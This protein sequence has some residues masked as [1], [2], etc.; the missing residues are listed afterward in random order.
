LLRACSI[1]S[2]SVGRSAWETWQRPGLR[3]GSESNIRGWDTS[4]GSPPRGVNPSLRAL[5]LPVCSRI[6][7]FGRHAWRGQLRA[8]DRVY[9]PASPLVKVCAIRAYARRYGLRLFVET[10]T[11]YGTTTAAVAGLFEKC[12]TVELSE[13]L[14]AQAARKF[15]G[16]NIECLQ[17][18]SGTV[19]PKIIAGLSA[20][21]LF[22]LDAH[23]TGGSLTADAGYDPILLEVEA[24][25]RS[26]FRH[27]A[28][29][30]DARGHNFEEIG[31]LAG[32]TRC[33]MRNDI[34][35]IAPA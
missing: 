27:V 3:R 28:L 34:I 25:V 16:T 24:V 2:A 5:P 30:D 10:G 29:I 1:V 6:V 35:R 26:P 19:L 7:Q 21:A 9:V 33:S 4:T 20:P 12:W 14:H 32:P 23:A 13:Q 22:W 31:R 15:A 8:T 11:C 18:D 17:G